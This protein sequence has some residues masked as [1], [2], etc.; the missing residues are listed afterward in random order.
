MCR[1]KGWQIVPSVLAQAGLDERSFSPIKIQG[2]PIRVKDN[3]LRV[4][5]TASRS[6]SIGQTGPSAS[7]IDYYVYMNYPV[8][9]TLIT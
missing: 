8:E 7:H 9:A 5:I 2:S 1:V 6:L 3:A 4:V